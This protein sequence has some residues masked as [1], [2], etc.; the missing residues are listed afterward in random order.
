M[1]WSKWEN[2]TSPEVARGD[3]CVLLKATALS[4]VMMGWEGRVRSAHLLYNQSQIL[5]TADFI[6]C[7]MGN[8]IA[9]ELILNFLFMFFYPLTLTSMALVESM[10][11]FQKE[12]RATLPI[13]Q[14]CR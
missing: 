2:H 13:L 4:L 6:R 3:L 5:Q 12:K 14:S 8:P 11:I 10:I 9:K 7:T 1:T